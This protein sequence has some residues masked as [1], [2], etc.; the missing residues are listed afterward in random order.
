MAIVVDGI[1][2]VV[3]VDE[4]VVLP[5][6]VVSDEEI[7][8]VG[9]VCDVSSVYGYVLTCSMMYNIDVVVVDNIDSIV[10][11]N[12]VFINCESVERVS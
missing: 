12:I 11:G 7:D 1:S 9:V 6:V 8:D 3:V 10:V 4:E 2:V 5:V